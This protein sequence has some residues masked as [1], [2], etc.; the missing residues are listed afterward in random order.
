[1]KKFYKRILAVVCIFALA[2]SINPRMIMASSD[3]ENYDY[4]DYDDT[5]YDD[6]D[7][8]DGYV[9]PENDYVDE[10]STEPFLDVQTNKYIYD[11]VGNTWQISYSASSTPT[12]SSSNK[13]IVSVNKEGYIRCNKKGKAVITIKLGSLSKKFTIEVY[14]EFLMVYEPKTVELAVGSEYR[15]GYF[16]SKTPTYSSSNKSVVTIDDEGMFECLKRGKSVISVKVGKIT[17]KFTV[18][19]G[20]QY[21]DLG[22]RNCQEVSLPVSI[23][24]GIDVVGG[25]AKY[26]KSSNSKVLKVYK[27]GDYYSVKALKKGKAVL[28]YTKN[29]KVKS[30]KV[31]VVDKPAID[32]ENPKISVKKGEYYYTVKVK[33]NSSESIIIDKLS[34]EE[35]SGGDGGGIMTYFL[36]KKVVLKP[37]TSKTITVNMHCSGYGIVDNGDVYAPGVVV[38]YKNSYIGIRYKRNNAKDKFKPFCYDYYGIDPDIG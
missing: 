19:V 12:F 25:D 27:D 6:T 32:I 21:I 1:M 24:T 35:D 3:D 11:Y 31:T 34:D 38:K 14:P 18:E 33:N 15:V 20:N 10:E 8:D 37:G 16:A 36:P 7:Y 26:I 28:T 5:D 9:E 29:R 17:K 2:L 4:E 23:E 13:S 30:V 22:T